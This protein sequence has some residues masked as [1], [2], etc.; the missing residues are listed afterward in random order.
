MEE[1]RSEIAGSVVR[2]SGTVRRT[3]EADPTQVIEFTIVIRPPVQ[4]AQSSEDLLAGRSSGKTR[5]Q[6]EK[7]LSADDADMR[8]VSDF[9]HRSGFH[10]L[11]ANPAER[12]LRVSGAVQEINQAFGIRLAYF[13]GPNGSFLSYDG[14]LTAP[15]SVSQRILAVLGLH[16]D[17]VAK[18]R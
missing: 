8:A 17:Q 10:V 16:R 11:E 1:S 2:R 18:P 4:A 12:R 13:D 14:P 9:A 7:E 5:D 6:V 15:A 3:G